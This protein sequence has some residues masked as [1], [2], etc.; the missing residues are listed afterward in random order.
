MNL[1]VR[2]VLS[3]LLHNWSAPALVA[4][5]IAVVLAVLVN[6]VYV[7][8]QR[9][10]RIERPTGMDLANCVVIRSLGFTEHYDH[11]ATIRADLDYLRAI[12]GVVAATAIDY[13]PLSGI[14]SSLGVMLMPDDPTHAVGTNYFEVD[15][16]AIP[17]LGLRLVAGRAFTRNDM[18]PPRMGE[19]ASITA[20]SVIITRALA[21]SLFPDGDALGKTLYDSYGW[22]SHP[23]TIVGIV[24]QMHGSRVASRILARV[25]LVPRVPYPDEPAVQYVVRAAPGQVDAVKRVAEEHLSSSNP[26]RIIEWVRTLEFFHTRS[27]LTDRNISIFLVAI[28]AALLALGAIGI[29]GLTQFNVGARTKQIGIRR[30]LG[31]RRIDIV[32][33]FLIENWLVATT[34]IV[35]GCALALGAGY[36]LSEKYALPRLDLY[37]LAGGVPVIWI[38][39]LLAAWHPARRAAL[40]SPAEATRSI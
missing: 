11:V 16:D 1:N 31:A 10:D 24:E 33:Y 14:S 15:Q 3:A 6:A 35:L 40:V 5:Q 34:G 30:A 19:T 37:Y 13:P 21:D 7:V 2:P 22:L 27:Y 12:P 28:T 25:L 26:D 18:L 17:A 38:V 23:A 20:P 9:L 8:R 29:F 39:A 32:S 4:V 36:W